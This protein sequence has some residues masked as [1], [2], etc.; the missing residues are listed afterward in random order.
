MAVNGSD[1][2]LFI[3]RGEGVYILE[4]SRCWLQKSNLICTVLDKFRLQKIDI[5]NDGCSH[6]II[7]I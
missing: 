6:F 1:C 4:A 7:V 2:M 5:K 3:I